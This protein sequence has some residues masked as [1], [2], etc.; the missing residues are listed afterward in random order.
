MFVCLVVMSSVFTVKLADGCTIQMSEKC[1]PDV[2]HPVKSQSLIDK[3]FQP[4]LADTRKTTETPPRTEKK[5]QGLVA[6]KNL[7]G[8]IKKLNNNIQTDILTNKVPLTNGD[9][10][11][12]LPDYT[13]IEKIDDLYFR[14]VC[15]FIFKT[16][17]LSNKIHKNVFYRLTGWIWNVLLD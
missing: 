4:L 15:I 14:A 8:H 16:F 12:D 13:V 17:V 2:S 1:S 7:P 9:G 3:K 10:E 11:L 6:K 5:F